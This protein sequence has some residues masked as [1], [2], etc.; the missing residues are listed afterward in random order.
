MRWPTFIR[1]G[2]KQGISTTMKYKCK[3]TKWFLYFSW[4]RRVSAFSGFYKFFNYELYS[5]KKMPKQQQKIK[6]KR[7]RKNLYLE[8]SKSLST[9]IYNSSKAV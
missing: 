3:L 6:Q 9:T 2:P 8:Y 5:N 1:N 4:N 7:K